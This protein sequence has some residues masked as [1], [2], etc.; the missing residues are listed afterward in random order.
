MDLEIVRTDVAVVGGGGAG[1]R[2][3][4]AAAQAYPDLDVTVI[5]KIYPLRSHTVA[6]E[7]GAAGVIDPEDS[8]ADHIADTLASGDGLC[9]PEVV[10]HVVDQA[11][12][13]LARL[14]RWGCP[15]SRTPEGAV[16]ARRFGGMSRARTWYAADRTGLH[17]LRTL[18]QTSVKLGIRRLDDHLVLDLLT[19][20]GRA[21]GLLAH[22]QREGR[23]V[24]VQAG[25]IVLATGGA[26]RA[27]RRSTNSAQV[28]GDGMAMA[29][30]A[31]L[32][33]RDME[34]VQYHPTALLGSGTLITEACRGE[35]GLLLNASGR[36]YL[37]DYGLGPE[38]PPGEPVTRRMELG[39]RDRL[40]QAFWHESQA[41]RTIAGEDGDAVHLDLRHL[42]P[43][44][45]RERLP[46]TAEQVGRLGL[47]PLADLIPVSPAVH[48][49]MG[50]IATHAPDGDGQ[51]VATGLP[52]LYAAGECASSGLHGANRLGSNSLAEVLVL[53]RAAGLQASAHAARRPAGAAA[54]ATLVRQAQELAAGHRARLGRGSEAPGEIRRELGQALETGAG[55]VRGEAGLAEAAGALAGLRRRYAGVRITDTSLVHNTDW[56]EVI[57]LGCMLDVAEAIVHGAQARR[58]SRGAHQ[59]HGLEP[60]GEP[61]HTLTYRRGGAEPAVCCVPVASAAPV[62]ATAVVGAP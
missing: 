33:L 4:I 61:A 39:P 20:E 17:L 46:Q 14:E 13:E 56:A 36:R 24:L 45:L 18:L 16:A 62:V 23:T 6:A 1:L 22:S 53:G 38:T 21:A 58:E 10:A 57:E 47:N 8:A 2:A 11:P 60:G 7:G 44:V 31:G 19:H 29:Y 51:A 49:T 54:P 40:S 27:F 41:G 12:R 52:G 48:Y 59:I 30:R 3:A 34:M 15:W 37:A 5:S 50:G 42:G 9:D 26:G 35:G 28:T 25:A 32:P 55:I 43:D